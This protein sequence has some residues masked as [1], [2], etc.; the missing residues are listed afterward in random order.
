MHATPS[1]ISITQSTH[2][3][4]EAGIA[5]FPPRK[6]TSDFIK[7]HAGDKHGP[8]D[9]HRRDFPD[10]RV[11]SHSALASIEHGQMLLQTAGECVA[12]DFVDFVDRQR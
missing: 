9:E 4:I 5:E 11:G 2:R 3:V 10:G 6:L 1:E 7:T 8:P 12:V